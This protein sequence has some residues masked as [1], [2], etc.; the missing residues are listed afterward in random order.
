ME[1]AGYLQ[2]NDPRMAL[3][4][5]DDRKLGTEAWQPYNVERK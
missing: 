4:D 5:G 2:R 1:K 3:A